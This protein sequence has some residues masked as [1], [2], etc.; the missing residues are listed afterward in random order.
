MSYTEIAEALGVPQG[1]VESRLHRARA[2]LKNKL[3]S[4]KS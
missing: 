2:D 3:K 4:Y 1:T